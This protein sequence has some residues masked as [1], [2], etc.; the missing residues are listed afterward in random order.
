MLYLRPGRT[1]KIG[2]M[3]V[4]ILDLENECI[5]LFTTYQ[6]AANYIGVSVMT[7]K[8]WSKN[9][10]LILTKD[11]KYYVCYNNQL[12]KLKRGGHANFI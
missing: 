5:E 7:I 9:G 4:G 12:H 10:D 2:V 1:N 6:Q 3:K 8:R 11:G